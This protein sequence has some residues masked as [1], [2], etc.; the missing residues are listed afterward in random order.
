MDSL[1]QKNTT[2]DYTKTTTTKKKK[3]LQLIFNYCNET[4]ITIQEYFA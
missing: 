1:Q 4:T 2:L 3:K